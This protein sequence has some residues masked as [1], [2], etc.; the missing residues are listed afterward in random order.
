MQPRT[1][2][3]FVTVTKHGFFSISRGGTL[4]VSITGPGEAG[5]VSTLINVWRATASRYFLSGGV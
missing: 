4:W 5:L 3:C 1:V 2:P